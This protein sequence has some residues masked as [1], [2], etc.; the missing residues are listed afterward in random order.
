[1]GKLISERKL[2][3]GRW[4]R[5]STKRRGR[6]SRQENFILQIFINSNHI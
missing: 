5:E 2:E 4:D 6:S 1:V 3:E